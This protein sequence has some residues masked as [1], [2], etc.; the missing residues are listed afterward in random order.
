[1]YA[2]ITECTIYWGAGKEMHIR[3]AYAQDVNWVD[4]RDWTDMSPLL[5]RVDVGHRRRYSR[6]VIQINLGGTA[7]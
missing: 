7:T 4:F 2:E 6:R 1:M 3:P 5:D